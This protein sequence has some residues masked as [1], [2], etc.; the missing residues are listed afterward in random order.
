MSMIIN[1]KTVKSIY[2]SLIQS[3][4]SF[5]LR[6][7]VS[8]TKSNLTMILKLKKN[9]R[10]ILNLGWRNCSFSELQIPTV[11]SLYIYIV[12]ALKFLNRVP[13]WIKTEEN[14]VTSKK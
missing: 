5:G 3:T 1:L 4:I 2:F 11:F 9:I 10:I 12:Y 14:R 7:Y 8:T 13:S 6:L